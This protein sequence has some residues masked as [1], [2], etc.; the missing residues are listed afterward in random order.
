MSRDK[1]CFDYVIARRRTLK[2]NK[3]SNIRLLKLGKHA[4]RIISF[5]K[6]HTYKHL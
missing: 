6:L 1:T 3:L 2:R 5:T 4:L